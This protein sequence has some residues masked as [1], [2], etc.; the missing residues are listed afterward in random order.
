M[1]LLI[2]IVDNVGKELI[3]LKNGIAEIFLKRNL[4]SLTLLEW[5]GAWAAPNQKMP[6]DRAVTWAAYPA[7]C[8]HNGSSQCLHFAHLSFVLQ[9]SVGNAFRFWVQ[10]GRVRVRGHRDTK[11]SCD[12]GT[13]LLPRILLREVCP[14]GRLAKASIV[15][16]DYG[17]EEQPSKSE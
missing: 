7:W 12:L 5:L 1:T 3:I 9:L 2:H 11:S 13:R 14:Q 6:W 4:W 8:V 17:Q 16:L 15:P 10:W